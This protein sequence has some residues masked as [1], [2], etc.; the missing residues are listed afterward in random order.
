MKFSL[1]I[2]FK[3]GR[4]GLVLFFNR[5]IC[6]LIHSCNSA[7]SQLLCSS[8]KSC[9]F[10]STT[11][12]VHIKP[13]NISSVV[14]VTLTMTWLSVPDELVCVFCNHADYLRFSHTTY[15]R[16]HV[17]LFLFRWQMP[18]RWWFLVS[19]PLSYTVNGGSPTGRWH[20]LHRWWWLHVVLISLS[21]SPLSLLFIYAPLFSSSTVYSLNKHTHF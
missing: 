8:I 16:V 10:R 7:N 1:S 13:K 15:L 20:C 17:L 5:H 11:V 14:S 12:N 9:R 21:L 4:Y 18:W 6:I 3:V 2:V 19:W